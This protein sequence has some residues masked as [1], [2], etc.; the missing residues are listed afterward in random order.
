MYVHR[1]LGIGFLA[2]PHAASRSISEALMKQFD[3]KKAHGH[4]Y[5]PLRKHDEEGMTF[6]C[7][8]RNHFDAFA[9]W[10]CVN[11]PPLYEGGIDARWI[12]TWLKGHSTP[13]RPYWR[14]NNLWYFL[15]EVPGVEVI[16][17]E[18]LSEE[19]NAFLLS[20]DIGP[21]DLPHVSDNRRRPESTY[22]YLFSPSG[23]AM[24]EEYFKDE[25]AELSYEWE[26]VSR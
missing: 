17:F 9:S 2:H 18:R 20:H 3:F 10:Y 21:I 13:K 23:R 5:G 1:G 15:K 4:H 22:Q 12:V 19:L 14:G 24:V 25:M 11:H 7:V 6:F 16:R 8:V 26:D